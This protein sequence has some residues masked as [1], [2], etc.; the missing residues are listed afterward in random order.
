M[1]PERW[2]NTTLSEGAKASRQIGRSTL[3]NNSDEVLSRL[4]AKLNLLRSFIVKRRG[5]DNRGSDGSNTPNSTTQTSQ[6]ASTPLITV[7]SSGTGGTGS[8]IL[9][10]ILLYIDK[11]FKSLFT[12]EDPICVFSYLCRDHF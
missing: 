3:V 6:Y 12:G 5:M 4:R 9:L 1:N 7:F 10:D 8:S 2:T 11:T